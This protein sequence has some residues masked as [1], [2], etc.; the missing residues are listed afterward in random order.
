MNKKTLNQRIL[1]QTILK[2]LI[3]SNILFTLSE[4]NVSRPVPQYILY[5]DVYSA[6][7]KWANAEPQE[8][9][10]PSVGLV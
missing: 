2:S 1:K 3:I 7:D 8:S 10:L 6:E 4:S 5:G 9:V